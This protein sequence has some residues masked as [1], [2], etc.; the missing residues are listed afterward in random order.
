[1]VHIS[2]FSGVYILTPQTQ[3]S[4]A[5][6]IN[7]GLLEI[8]DHIDDTDQRHPIGKNTEAVL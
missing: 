4:K 2:Y 7:N 1:M 6:L 5:I 3:N 8:E